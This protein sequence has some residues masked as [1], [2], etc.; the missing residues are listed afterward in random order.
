MRQHKPL[1][2]DLLLEGWLP[3]NA[4]ADKLGIPVRMLIARAK[5][6]EIRRREIAPGTSIFVYE[7]ES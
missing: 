2:S 5:R 4:A 3:P 1:A 6:G 7:T